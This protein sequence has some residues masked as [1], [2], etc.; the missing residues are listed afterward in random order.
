MPMQ[1]PGSVAPAASIDILAFVLQRN[2]VPPGPRALTDTT[3][4]SRALPAR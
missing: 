2:G 4:L 1:A 3:D